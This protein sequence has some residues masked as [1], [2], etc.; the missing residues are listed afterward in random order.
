LKKAMARQRNRL[1]YLGLMGRAFR[2]R[3]GETRLANSVWAI[4]L[5]LLIL[6]AWQFAVRAFQVPDIILPSP[7]DI[8]EYFVRRN[9]LFITH[10]WPTLI[11][12]IWGFALAVAGGVVL[13]IIV[14][15]TD[16]GRRAVMP[17][18]VVAQIVPKIAV[19]PLFMLWFG[20]G[21][22]SRVLIAFLVAFFPM[23]INTASGLSSVDEEVVLLGRA[24]ARSQWKFFLKIQLPHALP[25][26]FD[27]MKV[28]ITLAIIGVIVAEFVSSQSG[29]G[30]LIMFGNGRLDTPMM[31]TAIMVLSAMGLALYG[32]VSLLG[33]VVVYWRN[34]NEV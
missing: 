20:L 15:L 26:I 17:L 6:A 4:G 27:G 11:Q 33:R 2:M 24:F 1:V 29:L 30:Y 7:T 10:L 12:T 21:D 9:R 19:A 28:S 13:A 14:S 3:P 16:F 31:M 22:L 5:F 32:V 25:Y 18:L 23:V 8:A 34:P